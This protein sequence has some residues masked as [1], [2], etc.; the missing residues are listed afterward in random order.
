M[1]E[2]EVA[3]LADEVTWGPQE[4]GGGLT[5]RFWPRSRKG[6][7][8][9]QPGTRVSVSGVRQAWGGARPREGLGHSLGQES[10]AC[11]Q[12]ARGGVQAPRAARQRLRLRPEQSRT[13]RLRRGGVFQP[14]PS[15]ASESSVSCDRH[16]KRIANTLRV[17]F[18]NH[19]KAILKNY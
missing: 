2:V 17:T 18:C 9:A 7:P 13:Q 15:L 10:T 12:E 19:L 3:E 11:S 1:T 5:P 8:S 16:R 4:T 14:T 6:G